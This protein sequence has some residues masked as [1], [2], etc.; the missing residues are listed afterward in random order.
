MVVSI[1]KYL[2][3]YLPGD[4]LFP[5]IKTAHLEAT[6]CLLEGIYGKEKVQGS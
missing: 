3:T 6:E 2:C 1:Q 4:N 5:V